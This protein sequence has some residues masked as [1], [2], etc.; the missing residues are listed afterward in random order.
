MQMCTIYMNNKYKLV[1]VLLC[2]RFKK[3]LI[4]MVMVTFRVDCRLL[5][6]NNFFKSFKKIKF[7]ID[8][9]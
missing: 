7:L 9:N 3:K 6:L 4:Y 1:I 2:I 8:K 5:T